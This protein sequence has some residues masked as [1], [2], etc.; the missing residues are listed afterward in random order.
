MQFKLNKKLIILLVIIVVGTAGLVYYMAMPKPVTKYKFYSSEFQFRDDLR[1]ARNVSVYPNEDAILTAVWNPEIQNIS[2]T[3][4]DSTPSDNALVTVNAF[5]ITYKLTVGYNEFEWLGIKFLPNMVE[6]FEN[7][8]STN[9][10]LAIALIPPSVANVTSVEMKDGV[11]YISGKT[12]K[13]LDL[14]TIRFLMAA[15][16][17]KL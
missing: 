6:S 5:E 2:I 4:V 7:L 17:I 14:A 8:T 9:E 11:I 10:T 12:Q 1:A 16:R 15:L 13:E 3:F